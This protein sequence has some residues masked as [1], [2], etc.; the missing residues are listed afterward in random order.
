MQNLMNQLGIIFNSSMSN[1]RVLSIKPWFLSTK[2]KARWPCKTRLHCIFLRVHSN[3]GSTKTFNS[4]RECCWSW[5]TLVEI[6][7][8]ISKFRGY[9]YPASLTNSEIFISPLICLSALY[10]PKIHLP[11]FTI[12]IKKFK[13]WYIFKKKKI[14]NQIFPVIHNF[15]K[16][17][18]GCQ[19]APQI[20]S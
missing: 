6:I 14:L 9:N 16:G 11:K 18:S 20:Q 4:Y 10:Q 8:R 17:M 3:N 5:A 19:K 7:L 13:D 15:N 12:L 1:K 2:S